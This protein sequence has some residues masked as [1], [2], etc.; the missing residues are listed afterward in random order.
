LTFDDAIT[1]LQSAAMSE[2]SYSYAVQL[3][4]AVLQTGGVTSF[5]SP[6]MRIP[7][8]SIS[9]HEL[10]LTRG[11][12]AAADF[13]VLLSSRI[14]DIFVPP[15]SNDPAEN[16]SQ[17]FYAADTGQGTTTMSLTIS[18]PIGAGAFIQRSFV[19]E[20]PAFSASSNTDLVAD[21]LLS[22]RADFYP[23][24]HEFAIKLH[25]VGDFY[26]GVGPAIDGTTASAVY[27]FTLRSVSIPG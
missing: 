14:V 16:F 4:L 15:E 2:P 18:R 20:S 12:L 10:L 9:K 27:F 5:G 11:V 22:P 21:F 13:G 7:I 8:P 17:P 3:S 6:A 24:I 1:F 23:K 26:S 25:A 19:Q